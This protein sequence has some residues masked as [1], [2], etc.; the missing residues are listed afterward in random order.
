MALARGRY[1]AIFNHDDLWSPAHLQVTV[2]ALET[3]QADFAYTV[4]LAAY[5]DVRNPIAVGATTLRGRFHPG[6]VVPSTLW[7]FRRE[8]FERVGPWRPALTLRMAASHDWLLRVWRS[9]AKMIAVPRV[10]VF[11]VTSPV[12][13]QAYINRSDDAHAQASRLLADPAFIAELALRWH[14][15]WE[16]RKLGAGLWWFLYEW[17]YALAVQA[18]LLL[19]IFPARPRFWYRNFR[20]GA[21]IQRLRHLRGLPPLSDPPSQRNP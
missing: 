15:R 8:L 1:I 13:R 11:L 3:E 16:D 2:D 10:T 9:G 5:S 20:K 18:M 7:V 14:Y 17:I 21:M 4:G 12:Y 19:R 6:H